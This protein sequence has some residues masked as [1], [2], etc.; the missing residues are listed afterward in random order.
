M[1]TVNNL[2]YENR[3]TNLN[4]HNLVKQALQRL[5]RHSLQKSAIYGLCKSHNR[6]DPTLVVA[7]ATT[8]NT[9]ERLLDYK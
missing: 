5:L 3:K 9:Q 4:N 8:Q 1:G 2:L 7:S 6:L